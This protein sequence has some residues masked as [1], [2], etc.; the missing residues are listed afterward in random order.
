MREWKDS[1]NVK[2]VH[3]DLYKPSD[4]SNPSSE[5]YISLI[6]NNVFAEK[7]RTQS[8]ALWAQS[9]LETIFDE[10]HLSTKIDADIVDSWLEALTDTEMVV[11][12]YNFFVHLL[13]F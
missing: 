10:N 5:K 1:D 6:I 3:D 7:E 11:I 9:V 13:Y 8:N 12:L 2:R 4:P